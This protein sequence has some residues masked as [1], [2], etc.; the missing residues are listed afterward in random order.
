MGQGLEALYGQVLE[1]TYRITRLI[2]EGGMGAVYEAEHARLPRKFAIK[3][4]FPHVAS[5]EVAVER[6]HREALVTSELG[7]PHIVDVI[8][9]NHTP[10][11]FPYIVMEFLAGEDL[12]QRMARVGRMTPAA[13][14]RILEQTASALEAVHHRDII[15]RD[16]KPQNI[17]LCEK[18]G[19]DDYVKVVDFGISKIRGARQALTRAHMVM[20]TPYYMSPEQAKGHADNADRRADI[21]ALGGMLY[22][23]L[24]GNLPFQGETPD[25]VLYQ[26]VHEDPPGFSELGLD[27]APSVEEVVF[28]AIA[29]KPEDRWD[30]MGELAEAFSYAV[31]RTVIDFLPLDDIEGLEQ[32]EKKTTDRLEPVEEQQQA[33]GS[34]PLAEGKTEPLDRA[35][36]ISSEEQSPEEAG[37]EK[38]VGTARPERPAG[39]A[40]GL[41]PGE[42]T[43]ALSTSAPGPASSDLAATRPRPALNTPPV[44]GASDDAEADA[45]APTKVI[46]TRAVMER[47]RELEQAEQRSG[48]D[49]DDEIDTFKE[50]K[51]VAAPGSSLDQ[52]YQQGIQPGQPASP[53][54]TPAPRPL[55]D[56]TFSSTMGEVSGRSRNSKLGLFVVLALLLVGGALTFGAVRLMGASEQNAGGKATRAA[57]ARADK[58]AAGEAA[59]SSAAAAKAPESAEEKK[60]TAE[61]KKPAAAEEKKPVAAVTKK[62][63]A[64]VE[65]KPAAK[66]PTPAARKTRTL[67]VVTSPAGARVVVNGK[68]IGKTPIAGFEITTAKVRMVITRSG[69]KRINRTLPAGSAPQSYNLRLEARRKAPALGHLRV[70]TLFKGKPFRAF[71]F[72]NGKRAGESPL[73]IS[74]P[75]GSHRVEAWRRNIKASSK[76]VTVSA[77]KTQLVILKLRKK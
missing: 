69:H 3:V 56:T 62:P 64:T 55:K 31:E 59:S 19:V 60:P 21:F 49:S 28:Q 16:L 37:T 11:G 48:L 25:V 35:Q 34:G 77:G 27:I 9:F 67:N 38:S 14:N 65:K 33:E 61:E 39:T 17:F 20:G 29:K 58:P 6:F 76:R 41:G 44:Q 12:E 22:E 13:V 68:R 72:V 24:T 47:E 36:M 18:E 45:E 52:A 10:D 4:L 1:N 40:P 7:H 53:M 74:L 46:D 66:K 2:G 32:A 43:P 73:R 54:A 26:V 57:A 23:M 30:N 15:H 5:N 70:A 51:S 75:E 42:E 50:H 71:I 63:A 8:D